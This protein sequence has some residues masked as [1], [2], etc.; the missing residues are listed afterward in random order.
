VTNGKA[1]WVAIIGIMLTVGGVIW[2]GG[3][4]IG[5]I[6]Q[7]NENQRQAIEQLKDRVTTIT[8]VLVKQARGKAQREELRRQIK[9]LQEQVQELQR[10]ASAEPQTGPHPQG[11]ERNVDPAK[12]QSAENSEHPAR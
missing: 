2:R 5:Q 12:Q 9:R 8:D 1:T 10:D 4:T 7:T 6:E 11:G 3:T